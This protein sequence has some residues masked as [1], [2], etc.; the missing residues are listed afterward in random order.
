MLFV[1]IH[2]PIKHNGAR[3]VSLGIH[4][5]IVEYYL[6]YHLIQKGR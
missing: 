2:C 4:N 3:C 1:L 5:T 6:A